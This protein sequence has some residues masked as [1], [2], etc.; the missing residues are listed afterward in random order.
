MWPAPVGGMAT[1]Q[2]TDAAD[3]EGGTQDRG[4]GPKSPFA[5]VPSYNA[6]GMIR[7]P[8]GASREESPNTTG[9]GGG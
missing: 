6:L 7:R 4:G 5:A 2:S 1:G 9:Y 8:L 3:G